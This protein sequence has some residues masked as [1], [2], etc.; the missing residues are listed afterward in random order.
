[1]R[2]NDLVTL[3]VAKCFT[4]RNGGKRC[5]PLINNLADD[6]GY[7]EGTVLATAED[8]K[9]WQNSEASQG[10]T[11]AGETKLPPT[12][13]RAKIYSGRVYNLLRARCAPVYSYRRHPGMALV[14]C[15]ETGQEIY[16]KRELL[17][18]AS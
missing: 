13:Y 11:S 15:T 14:L 7:I 18:V 8:K 2:K 9:Q 1:M 4:M 12:C 5:T 10:M 3:N 6:N 17:E 16:V